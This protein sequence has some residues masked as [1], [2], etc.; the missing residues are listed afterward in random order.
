MGLTLYSYLCLHICFM[1]RRDCDGQAEM[2]GK[3]RET[4]WRI[5]MRGE[6]GLCGK[7]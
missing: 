1:Y 4:G 5:G 6:E 2:E 7:G 3:R